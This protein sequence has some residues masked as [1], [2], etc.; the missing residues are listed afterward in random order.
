V[1][2]PWKMVGLVKRQRPSFCSTCAIA[3]IYI[4]LVYNI[5]I[6]GTF[7]LNDFTRLSRLLRKIL[8]FQALLRDANE[9]PST[10]WRLRLRCECSGHL[11]C[12]SI[13]FA[14]PIGIANFRLTNFR[15]RFHP[16]LWIIMNPCQNM[17]GISF[18]H[19]SLTINIK[20]K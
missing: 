4:R 5:Y 19:V 6:T 8:S 7:I 2:Y 1:P 10:T 15:S 20:W 12:N 17:K 18:P 16:Y 14:I 3:Y 11:L 9:I 13:S